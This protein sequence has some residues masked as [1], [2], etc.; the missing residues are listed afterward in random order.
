MYVQYSVQCLVSDIMNTQTAWH[1]YLTLKFCGL[2]EQTDN[3]FCFISILYLY[4]SAFI[5]DLNTMKML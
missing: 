2:M 4:F 1:P 3:L 5:S